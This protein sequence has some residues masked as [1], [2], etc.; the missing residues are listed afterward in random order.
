MVGTTS[1]AV[2]PRLAPCY[3]GGMMEWNE[4][5]AVVESVAPGSLAERAGVRPG[6]RV[7]AINGEAFADLID[8]RFLISDTVA[9]L[10]LLRDGRPRSV[11]IHK[12]VDEGL[13]ITSPRASSTESAGAATP[14]SFA[15]FTRCPRGCAGPLHS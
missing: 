10:D 5:G 8:Y 11:Q 9:R 13:G 4:R 14:A 6:D 15:S 1:P 2:A 7:T 3:N 12:E